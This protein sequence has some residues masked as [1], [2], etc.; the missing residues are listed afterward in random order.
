MW[1]GRSLS[2]AKPSG[3]APIS[4]SPRLDQ[5][6]LRPLGVRLGGRL[7]LHRLVAL[8]HL[9]QLEHGLVVLVLVGDQH[10]VDEAAGQQRVLGRLELQPVEDLQR[11]LAHL[12]EV[13]AK[14]VAAQDRQL[15]A[16]AP[17]VL[18][19]VVEAAELAV[20][21][22]PAT[23]R[24]H[25]PQLLEVGDVAQVPRQWAED[26]RIDAVQLLVGERLDEPEG[27]P[28]RLGQALRDRILLGGL[29]RGGDGDRL[30][31]ASADRRSRGPITDSPVRRSGITH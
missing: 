11:A 7:D 12:V 17:R 31:S 23:H 28:S 16:C 20:Q 2:Y 24:L 9:D 25:Q 15:A 30:T 29:D 21:R 3:P 6:H 10:L 19:R 18:D 26:R 4:A 14:L 27:S 1:R 5:D 22:L 13:G 8:D